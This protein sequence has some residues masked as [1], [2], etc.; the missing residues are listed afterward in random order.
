VQLRPNQGFGLFIAYN[1]DEAGFLD[2]VLGDFNDHYDPLPSAS[3]RAIAPGGGEDLSRFTGTYR[4][5]D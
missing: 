4:L 3:S 5:S 2:Q 1:S